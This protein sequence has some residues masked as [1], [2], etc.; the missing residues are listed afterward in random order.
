[1]GSCHVE[2]R[3]DFNE[4]VAE[5]ARAFAG[6]DH[7]WPPDIRVHIVVKKDLYLSVNLVYIGRC[8]QVPAKFSFR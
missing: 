7:C 2:F 4:E 3:V 8:G 1:M 5:K 6:A